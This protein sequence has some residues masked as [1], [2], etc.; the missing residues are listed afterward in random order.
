MDWVRKTFRKLH[1]RVSSINVLASV[2]FLTC[3]FSGNFSLF[4]DASK[5][6][7][8]SMCRIFPLTRDRMF[9]QFSDSHIT[10]ILLLHS[11]KVTRKYLKTKKIGFPK[12]DFGDEWYQITLTKW[13]QL[14][15]PETQETT[16]DYCQSF[17]VVITLDIRLLAFVIR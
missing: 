17:T 16:S 3:T 7:P 10:T 4:M 11:A 12:G 5:Q 6:S 2:C 15:T 8:K 1:L 13:L 9:R 14:N